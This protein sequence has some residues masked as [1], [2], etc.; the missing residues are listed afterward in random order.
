MAGAA[1][2]V[3]IVAG[4]ASGDSLG[5]GLIRALRARRP[6]LQVMGIGGDKMIAE[7]FESWF[8]LE[9]LAVMGLVE[10]LK[11][12]PELLGIRRELKRRF[13]AQRPDVFIGIDAPDFNLDLERALRA[14]GL[15]TA[16][17]V[18]PTVWAWRKGRIHKI[19]QAVDLMLTLFPFE[20]QIYRD[21]GVGVRCVGHPLADE[22][23]VEP[24]REAARAAL[25]LAADDR[26]LVVM[27]GS[28]GSEVAQMGEPFIATAAWLRARVPGLK[29]LI[30]AASGERRQQ[31]EALL[32][33]QPNGGCWQLLNGQSHLAMAAADA[34][35]MAS[36][37]TTLEAMLL[38]TPM[39]VAYRMPAMS[40][41]ILSRLVKVPYI[42]LP[43][44]LA[45]RELVPERMQADVRPEVLGPL[46]LERLTDTRTRTALLEAFTEIHQQLRRGASDSAAEA[47]LDLTEVR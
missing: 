6:D 16:H 32:A 33:G 9:R 36:G 10:P 22:L 5:A 40:Y 14:G 47:L 23:P 27:P 4:E 34:V 31:L 28:R 46:L 12:L 25:G 15:R 30:P 45:G 7:G 8:P 26:V 13:L 44:L 35:L 38:K 37:T 41:T 43:N 11:R 20:E 24:E 39:V 1:F 2:K 42:A 3:G 21:H 18:S 19:A 17:Y 29:V